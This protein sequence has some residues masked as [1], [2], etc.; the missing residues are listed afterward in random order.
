MAVVIDE[1]TLA[2][3]AILIV[4]TM[5]QIGKQGG[6]KIVMWR[7]R[8]VRW[9]MRVEKQPD[10]TAIRKAYNWKRITTHSLPKYPHN[11]KDWFVGGPKETVRIFGGPQWVYN[12]NDSRPI[13]LEIAGDP[14]DPTLIHSA[15]ENKSIEAFNGLNKKPDKFRWG[16]FGFAIFLI[17][18][19]AIINVWYGYYF[20]LNANCALHSKACPP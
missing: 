9:F 4:L 2:T 11:G 10:G 3:I 16:M 12:Y 19:L 7:L 13:P 20:G 15:F 18:I 14:I 5:I 6:P 17:I 8:G 1:T